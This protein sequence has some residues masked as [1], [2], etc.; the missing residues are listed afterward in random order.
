LTGELAEGSAAAAAEDVALWFVVILYS[1]FLLHIPCNCIFNNFQGS[2]YGIEKSSGKPIALSWEHYAFVAGAVSSG[3]AW[4]KEVWN[5]IDTQG[6][7]LLAPQDW[8]KAEFYGRQTSAAGSCRN[9]GVYHI[10]VR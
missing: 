5:E 7:H 3:C 1:F 8:D 10:F 4:S 2:Y 9:Y 6:G